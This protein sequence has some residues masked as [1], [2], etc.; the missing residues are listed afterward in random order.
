MPI[1]PLTGLPF[2][3]HELEKRHYERFGFPIPDIHPIA[4]FIVKVAHVNTW[5]LYWTKDPRT[6]K[7]ILSCY[8]PAEGHTVYDHSY[9]WS[10]EF[11]P[12]VYGRDV[13]FS[14]PFFEQYF[15][16]VQEIPKSNL[17]ILKS[18]NVDY[19]NNVL[20]CH[21]CYLTFNSVA[22]E[23]CYYC[24]RGSEN[25]DCAY[26]HSSQKCE[27]CYSCAN[28]RECYNVQFSEFSILC[29][30]S[31]FLSNCIDCSDCYQCANLKTAR[32]C[33]Q[34]IQYTKEEYEQQMVGIDLSSYKV[35][36]NEQEKWQAFLQSQPMQAERNINCEDSSGVLLTNCKSCASCFY[37]NGGENCFSSWGSKQ[38][39]NCDSSGDLGAEYGLMN[40]GYV[41]SK[42]CAYCFMVENSYDLLYSQYIVQSHDCFGCYGLKKGQYCIMNK[43]YGEEE[44]TTL[45]E[46]LIEH[47]KK[48]GEWGKFFLARYS[49]FPYRET[50][51]DISMSV[52]FDHR[53]GVV[54]RIG[55]RTDRDVSDI[56]LPIQEAIGAGQIPDTLDQFSAELLKKTF[57]CEKTGK[58]YKITKKE[59]ELYQRF[60]VAIPRK[61][62]RTTFEE[63][64]PL[65]QPLPN[66]TICSNCSKDIYSYIHPRKTSRRLLCDECFQKARV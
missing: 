21:N 15:E 37:L 14:R 16:M 9:W 12:L 63:W 66:E 20:N 5:S 42:Q 41:N 55:L 11:D 53:E 48:T 36:Q 18:E 31:R 24:L 2:E 45:K 46:R 27:L 51:A 1:C 59:L 30:S 19:C 56:S 35:F 39:E 43:Q 58:Q 57:L 8:D 28:C 26:V 29:V 47:M 34:N 65:L 10:D 25:R 7:D 49:S 60:R 38:A 54:E 22:C 40:I 52:L 17:T 61:Q 4:R 32:Y 64:Y 50:L 33:I 13:D 44:Y 23:D 3:H 6:S 62:W